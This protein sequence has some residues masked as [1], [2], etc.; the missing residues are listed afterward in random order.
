[1]SENL[2]GAVEA[3]PMLEVETTVEFEFDGEGNLISP[4]APVEEAVGAH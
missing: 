1:M 4:F 3:N 2:R